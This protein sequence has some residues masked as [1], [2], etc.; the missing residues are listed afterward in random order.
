MGAPGLALL[1][2]STDKEAHSC[3][4][5]HFTALSPLIIAVGL[6][7]ISQV[8][9]LLLDPD[10][11]VEASRDGGETF[12]PVDPDMVGALRA[13][14]DQI[15]EDADILTAGR[16]ED[17]CQRLIAIA[18]AEAERLVN[19]ARIEADRIVSEA[20]SGAERLLAET[21]A[22]ADRLKAAAAESQAGAT[23]PPAVGR[24]PKADAA[25]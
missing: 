18:T 19:D 8:Q 24:K 14:T 16:A 10:L 23:T 22:E 21:Q 2:I 1:R 6:L 13:M 17:E 12:E 25:S 3:A 4:Y 20:R 15:A 5:Q 9:D 7:S 11:K